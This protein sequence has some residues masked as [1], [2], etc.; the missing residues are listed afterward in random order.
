MSKNS[1]I[2]LNE[3]MIIN[4]KNFT[5]TRERV[6]QKVQFQLSFQ[7]KSTG[8]DL[9]REEINKNNNDH[10]AIYIDHGDSSSH[11]SSSSSTRNHLHANY[12]L[13]HE[14]GILFITCFYILSE[15][16]EK[17]NLRSPPTISLRHFFFV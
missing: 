9:L 3:Q 14:L 13:D 10:K 4:G 17:Q 12:V 1:E 11:S 5:N 7:T 8:E 15:L 2:F 16:P 6:N